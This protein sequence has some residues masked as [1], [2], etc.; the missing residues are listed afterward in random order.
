MTTAHY[1]N[2]FWKLYDDLSRKV[3]AGEIDEYRLMYLLKE[4]RLTCKDCSPV[5]ITPR[6]QRQK[7]ARE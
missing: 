1:C 3:K 7:E 2:T 6:K 5:E 4:H